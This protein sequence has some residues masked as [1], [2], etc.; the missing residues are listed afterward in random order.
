ML[1]ATRGVDSTR[2][3]S[4]RVSTVMYVCQRLVRLHHCQSQTCYLN[5]LHHKSRTTISTP[6]CALVRCGSATLGCFMWYAIR[7]VEAQTVVEHILLLLELQLIRVGDP[8]HL[9]YNHFRLVSS[10]AM[11]RASILPMI[12]LRAT[13]KT[14]TTRHLIYWVGPF[15]L[16]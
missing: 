5:L 4:L 11:A 2:A 10:H 7:V 9:S 3:F 12:A 15:L 1:D 6:L 13:T 8:L 16:R 14:R